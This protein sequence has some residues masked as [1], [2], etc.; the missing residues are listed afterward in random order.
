MNDCREI[1]EVFTGRVLQQWFCNA[2]KSNNP[3]AVKVLIQLEE[4]IFNDAVHGD[5][6]QAIDFAEKKNK[7]IFEMLIEHMFNDESKL[8][9]KIANSTCSHAAGLAFSK[10]RL[11]LAIRLQDA[12]I[13]REKIMGEN[14]VHGGV[15]PSKTL[16][17]KSLGTMM[18]DPNEFKFIEIVVSKLIEFSPNHFEKGGKHYNPSL[19]QYGN[20]SRSI[21]FVSLR[22]IEQSLVAECIRPD[23][24]E[25]MAQ[26]GQQAYNQ[27]SDWFNEATGKITDEDYDEDKFISLLASQ[28]GS[29]VLD[30]E[31]VDELT[32]AQV[33]ML[34]NLSNNYIKARLGSIPDLIDQCFDFIDSDLTLDS[35]DVSDHLMDEFSFPNSLAK[36]LAEAMDEVITDQV[37]KPVAALP[38]GLKVRDV[39]KYLKKFLKEN[40]SRE[41]KNNFSE[42]IKQQKLITLFNEDAKGRE[43]LWHSYFYAYLDV[44]KAALP[45][46]KTEQ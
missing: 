30:D 23:L 15:K 10:D 21:D 26:T 7:K 20:Q 25:M 28:W 13:S 32:V 39:S 9:H 4:G 2:I 19:I 44:L 35:S 24:A 34:K 46:P 18:S 43:D 36:F 14:D 5:Y 17:R 37:S 31:D 11:D 42:I 27:V 29:L 45:S 33:L 6:I 22:A 3:D 41:F 12:V 38:S 8:K 40:A 1:P 16:I